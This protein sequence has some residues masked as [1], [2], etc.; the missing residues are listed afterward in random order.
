[1]AQI[2]FWTI[3]FSITGTATTVLLGDRNILAGNLLN[4]NK[5]ISI[6]FHWRF[7]LAMLC[8]FTARYSFMIINNH[9]LKIPELARNST[10]ITF[11]ITSVAF[12]LVLVANHLFLNERLNQQQIIGAILIIIGVGVVLR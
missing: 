9:I 7:I 5:F 2:I 6:I 8:A 4:F 3:I 12:I 10:T 11:L 1:M